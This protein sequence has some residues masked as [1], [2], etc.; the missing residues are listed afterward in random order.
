VSYLRQI[1]YNLAM[2]TST[3]S[4]GARP[5]V[6]DIAA[7]IQADVMEGVIPSGTWLRQ[8]AIAEHSA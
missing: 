3:R 2:P 6:A 8:Q 1:G 5:L 7:V 4:S